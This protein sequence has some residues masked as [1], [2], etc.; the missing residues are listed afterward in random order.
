MGNPL[1]RFI[2][3]LYFFFPG[4]AAFIG[5]QIEKCIAF[6]TRNKYCRRCDS[7]LKKG[8]DVKEHDCRKNWE[9]SSKAMAS[10]MCISML[11]NLE[12][13][14]VCVGTIIMDNDSTTISK[15]RSE[16]KAEL[17]N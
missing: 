14:D 13:N 12:S 9:D 6:S 7:A 5:N 11:K 3:I 2:Y 16:V 15:A 4:H 8:C 17:K 10:D 1:Y